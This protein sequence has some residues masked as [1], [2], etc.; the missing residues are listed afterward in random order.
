MEP[1]DYVASLPAKGLRDHLLEAL[2]VWFG[3]NERAL[4]TIKDIINTLHNVSLMYVAAT[5]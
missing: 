5:T 3:L 2:N 4:S 1:Y